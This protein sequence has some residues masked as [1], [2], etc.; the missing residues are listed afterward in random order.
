MTDQEEKNMDMGTQ[1]V[2]RL[3][4]RTDNKMLGGVAGGLADYFGIDP[5]WVRL[6]FVAAVF[7]GGAG[8]LAYIV[9]YVVM[10]TGTGGEPSTAERLVERVAHSMRNTPTL[11]G[12]GLVILGAILVANQLFEWR[13]GVIWGFALIFF[14]VLLFVQRE[15]RATEEPT[16]VSAVAAP[17]AAPGDTAVLPMGAPPLPPGTAPSPPPRRVPRE[18]SGLGW[19]TLGALLVAIGVVTLLDLQDVVRLT[20]GQY[21][22]MAVATIGVGLLVGAWYGR[23]RWLI[24]PGLVLIPFMLAASL[25]HVPFEGGVGDRLFRPTSIEAVEPE[26]H[27]VAGQMLL[28]LNEVPFGPGT[29]TIEATTV[30]GRILVLVPENVRVEIHAKTGAGQVSLFGQTDEGLNVDVRRIFEPRVAGAPAGVLQLDLEAALG[31]VEVAFD[32]ESVDQPFGVRS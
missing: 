4:R 2:R 13:S 31:Q 20:A 7:L 30:V 16:A 25:I 3:I 1:Q 23:A 8:I 27:L 18:R 19:M 28:D 21:L 9:L 12:A 11:I 24:V 22:A 15:E 14:G 10:P 32:L 17:P 5:V 29:Y 26:Y 6:G